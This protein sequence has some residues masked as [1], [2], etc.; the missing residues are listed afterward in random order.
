MGQNPGRPEN[1]RRSQYSKR[2]R[3][4]LRFV[5]LLTGLMIGFNAVFYLW[6]AESSFF[7]GYLSLNARACAWV[8]RLL[9]EDAAA[10]ET[11][12]TSPRFGLE[13]KHGCDALQPS[14][15]FI[16]AM[17]AS[18]VA[19]PLRQRVAPILIGTLV[20]LMLNVVRIISLYYAGIYYPSAF[21]TLHLDVWQAAFIFS[22]LIFWLAWALRAARPPTTAPGTSPDATGPRP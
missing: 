17:L 5:L 1:S 22:P 13:L 16:F 9:G 3:P 14:A 10:S 19:R 6:L 2:G 12:L 20:L 11:L 15:F 4:V 7:T 18:P 21:E 8:L